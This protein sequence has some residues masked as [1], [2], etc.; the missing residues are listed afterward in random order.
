MVVGVCEI[1]LSIYEAN[2]LKDK[3]S[4]IKSLIGRLSSRFNISIGEVD[5]HDLWQR[6]VIGISVISTDKNHANEVLSK[7][8]DFID[9]DSR[10]EIINQ[11]IE[12]L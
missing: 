2:S 1:E 10:V 6:S 3:R 11:N 8:I 5:M 12:I 9:N 7:V 4:V